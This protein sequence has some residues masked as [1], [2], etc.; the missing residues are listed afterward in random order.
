M[1]MRKRRRED[2]HFGPG[3]PRKPSAV[4]TA[5]P[6]L[7]SPSMG[8]PTSWPT[9]VAVSIIL[10]RNHEPD[11]LERWFSDIGL[12][13]RHDPAIGEQ[14][15]AFLKTHAVRSTVVAAA[16][17]AAPT[18]KAWTIPKESIVLSALTWRGVIAGPRS[19]STERIAAMAKPKKLSGVRV[20]N[21]NLSLAGE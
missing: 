19:E 21:V 9:K 12:D 11:L 20:R 18:K 15:V 7:Q 10:T 17:S 13:V 3:S 14:V 16:S 2:D 1:R 4:F 8:R 6:S 5:I